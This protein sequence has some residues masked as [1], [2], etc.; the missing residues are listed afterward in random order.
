MNVAIELIDTGIGFQRKCLMIYSTGMINQSINQ[1]S[2]DR[3]MMY[4][5]PP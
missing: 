2:Y 4:I 1:S 5:I 3:H